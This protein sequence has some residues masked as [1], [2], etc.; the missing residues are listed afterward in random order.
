MR[1]VVRSGN[2]GGPLLG[3]DGAVLGIV[4]ATARDST[5]TGFALTETRSAADATLASCRVRWR[6][7]GLHARLTVRPDVQL[8]PAHQFAADQLGT[9]FCGKCPTPSRAATRTHRLT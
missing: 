9:S 5:D 4:F 7:A 1:A 3:D 2:S 6:P 8:R